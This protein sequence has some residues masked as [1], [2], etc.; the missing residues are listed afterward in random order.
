M[1]NDGI[2]YD[3]HSADACYNA[4]HTTDFAG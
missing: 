2:Q 1:G 3:Y 4:K